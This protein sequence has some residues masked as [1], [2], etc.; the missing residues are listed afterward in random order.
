MTPLPVIADAKTCPDGCGLCCAEMGTPPMLMDEY[1]A[2]PPALQWDRDAHHD[3]YGDALPCLWFDTEAKRCKHY[4]HRPL[5]C[6]EAVVPG[7]EDC[8][9]FRKVAGLRPL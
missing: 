6:R 9:L 4:E 5:T 1:A 8:T 2:L 3:R 7:D